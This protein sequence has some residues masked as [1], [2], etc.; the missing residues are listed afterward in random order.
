MR[1]VGG[2]TARPA[3]LG[4]GQRLTAS[5]C[6]VPGERSGWGGASQGVGECSRGSLGGV[7]SQGGPQRPWCSTR[8]FTLS[9]LGAVGGTSAWK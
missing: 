1:R 8:V 6:W 9:L 7:V 4:T 3:R 2:V 5:A